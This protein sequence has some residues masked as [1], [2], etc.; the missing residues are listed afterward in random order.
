MNLLFLKVMYRIL[1]NIL[2]KVR[3]LFFHLIFEGLGNVLLEMLDCGVPCI[4]TDCLAGPREIL[5]DDTN[6][7]QNLDNFE[8]AKYDILVSVLK[9]YKNAVNNELTKEEEQ[10]AD[11]IICLLKDKA[12]REYYRKKGIER[13]EDFSY[14]KISN[15]WIELIEDKN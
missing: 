11:A 2:L 4:A 6:I 1:I 5:D 12:L 14:K 13:A 15:S 9:E 8:L 10:M 7:K 3:Y